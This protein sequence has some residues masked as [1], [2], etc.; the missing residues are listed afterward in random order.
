MIGHRT[1][2]FAETGLI[3][4][5][6]KL[7]SD[8][9]WIL[10]WLRRASSGGRKLSA[11][12]AQ[13]IWQVAP[14]ARCIPADQR[15]RYPV[16]REQYCSE[17]GEVYHDLSVNNKLNRDAPQTAQTE[18]IPEKKRKRQPELAADRAERR[19]HEELL[20]ERALWVTRVLHLDTRSAQRIPCE[21]LSINVVYFEGSIFANRHQLYNARL[22]A[23]YN[24]PDKFGRELQLKF[25]K[26]SPSMSPPS[27][28][29][30]FRSEEHSVVYTG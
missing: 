9:F 22:Q 23:A 3:S 1:R 10:Y 11:S 20:E 30:P 16:Y 26:S 6:M 15:S 19:L 28:P 18:T 17:D 2:G 27:P 12:R 29:L 7:E 14:P 4:A 21:A 24:A 13:F 5:A 25:D 8:G